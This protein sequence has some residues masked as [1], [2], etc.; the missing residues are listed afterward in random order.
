M[1]IIPREV[2]ILGV[3]MTPLLLAGIVG[4]LMAFFSIIIL[5][6]LGVTKYFYNLMLLFVCLAVIFT[7]IFDKVIFFIL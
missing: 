6:R 4:V 1:G 2:N 7:L 5:T 3:Y